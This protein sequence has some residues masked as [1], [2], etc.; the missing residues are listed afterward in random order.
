MSEVKQRIQSEFKTETKAWKWAIVLLGFLFLVTGNAVPRT[1]D[2]MSAAHHDWVTAKLEFRHTPGG[3]LLID[4][5][6]SATRDIAGHWRV[7][8]FDSDGTRLYTRAGSGNYIR[9]DHTSPWSWAA[10]H[11]T[12]GEAPPIPWGG[13]VCVMYR[14]QAATGVVQQTSP[15][16]FDVPEQQER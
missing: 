10:F 5:E 9:G 16:C 15:Q 11:E 2:R 14:L 13:T 7:Q 12:Q 8:G 4:Y 3:S 1:I 6:R